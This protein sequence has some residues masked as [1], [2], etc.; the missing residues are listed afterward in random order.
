MAVVLGQFIKSLS[1]SG[2]MTVE[3]VDAF[4]DSLPPERTPSDGAGLAKELV[5][6][7]KLTKFQAQAIYQGKVKG[8]VLDQYVILDRIGQ[9]GMGR[10][11]KAKHK[12]MERVVALKTLPSSATKPRRAVQRFHRE[13]MV[14]ARLIHPNIVTA[15][16]AREDQGVHFLVCRLRGYWCTW[17]PGEDM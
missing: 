15:Y 9:G 4:L 12:A 17:T 16:D 5:N 7:K 1:K 13:I 10:V 6:R 11:Y 8:L 14:A 2:L 3:E